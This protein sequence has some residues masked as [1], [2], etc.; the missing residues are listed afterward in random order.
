MV[1]DTDHSR[2]DG[3]V[4]VKFADGSPPDPTFLR[5]MSCHSG[6]GSQECQ[7]RMVKGETTRYV[8][9]RVQTLHPGRVICDLMFENA[10]LDEDE[11]MVDCI[12]R[13]GSKPIIVK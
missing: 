11:S 8:R 13:P 9:G 12:S 10:E 1:P 6:D 5:V 7:I 3:Y 4:F 2:Q